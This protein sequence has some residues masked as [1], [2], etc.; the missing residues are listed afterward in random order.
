MTLARVIAEKIVVF[1]VNNCE[2]VQILIR[3]GLGFGC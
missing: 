1:F 3:C 2:C